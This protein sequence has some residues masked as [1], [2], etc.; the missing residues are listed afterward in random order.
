MLRERSTGS[1]VSRVSRT[2]L[3]EASLSKVAP[4]RRQNELLPLFS[5]LHATQIA[6]ILVP[7][8]PQKRASSG[9]ADPQA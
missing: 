8:R 5:V 7:Q 4:Q 1:N 6:T 3:A 9:F 2:T